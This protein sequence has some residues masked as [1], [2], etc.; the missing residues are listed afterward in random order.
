MRKQ[1]YVT[2][3]EWE[4]KLTNHQISD[5]Y[6][7]NLSSIYNGIIN[8]FLKTVVLAKL[9]L[10]KSQD[11]IYILSENVRVTACQF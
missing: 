8:S 7:Q 11:N 9:S 5:V 10:T 1:N 3:N 6:T 4:D 2:V